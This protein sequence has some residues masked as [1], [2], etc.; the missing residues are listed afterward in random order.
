MEREALRLQYQTK[1]RSLWDHAAMLLGKNKI[2]LRSEQLALVINRIWNI[3]FVN[4][5]KI[6]SSKPAL[7]TVANLSERI[8]KSEVFFLTENNDWTSATFATKKTG[9]H[10]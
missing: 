8:D 4:F 2:R 7:Q 10:T 1:S 5:D 9:S 6:K 3:D